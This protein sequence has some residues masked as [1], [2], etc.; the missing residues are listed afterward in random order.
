MSAPVPQYEASE[1]APDEFAAVAERLR[2]I[3]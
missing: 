1:L 2:F 3:E